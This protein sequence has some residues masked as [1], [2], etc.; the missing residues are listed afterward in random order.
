MT[1]PV[2]A[3]SSFLMRD[4]N[5]HVIRSGGTDSIPFWGIIIAPVVLAICSYFLI[6]LCT[7]GD[8]PVQSR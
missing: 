5:D 7:Q 6:I 8:S 1:L 2:G 3:E 4:T